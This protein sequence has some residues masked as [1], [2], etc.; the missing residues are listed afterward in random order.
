MTLEQAKKRYEE[1][2]FIA[3]GYPLG[4]ELAKEV[5]ADG[6]LEKFEKNCECFSVFPPDFERGFW[7]YVN[8]WK[9]LNQ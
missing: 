1:Y 9:V 5:I 8:A 7:E 4:R 6:T 3:T 2:M